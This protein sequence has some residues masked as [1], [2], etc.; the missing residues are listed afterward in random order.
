MATE[1][2]V[3]LDLGNDTLKISYAYDGA[4]GES[5]GKLMVGD[6]VNHVAIPAMA[7]YDEDERIW[8]FADELEHTA[9]K[10][11][12][13]V[14]KIKSILTM[15][16][17]PDGEE[18]ASEN[19]EY[20]TGE[21]L[22]PKFCFPERSK[23]EPLFSTLVEK[24]L[25]FKA[26]GTTPKSLCEDF[27]KYVK[28]IVTEQIN[29]L[30]ADS[31]VSFAPLKNIA[32]VYPPKQG[33]NYVDE[34]TRLVWTA[35]GEEPQTVLTSTQ[36]LGLLAFHKR[37]IRDDERALIFDMGDETVS[38]AKVWLNDNE[39]VRAGVLIDSRSA[40]SEPAD[41]GGS[42]ID[43]K[44][45]GFIADGIYHR[46]SIGSPSSGEVGHIY[47]NGLFSNQY[48]M[49]KDIKKSKTAMPLAGT[50]MFR[51]GVPITV[52]REVLVQRLITEYDFEMCVGT[53]ENDGVAKA[54]MEYIFE[55]LER[56]VNRDI[57]KI[58][59]AGG[60]IETH[61]L[62]EYIQRELSREYGHIRVYKFEE[63]TA[64]YETV[65]PYT[66]QFY[67]ASAYSSSLGGAIV[68]MRNYSVDN[69]LSYSYGTW[70][71]HPGS[72]KKH[73]KL[74][75]ERGSLLKEKETRFSM[76]ASIMVDRK[77]QERIDGDELFS[78]IINTKEI[79]AHRYSDTL[80]YEDDFLI[81]GNSGDEDR[82]RAEDVIDLRI[83]GGGEGTEVNFYYRDE[84]VSIYT[85]T[86]E[87][88]VNFEEGF[89]VDQN[90]RA[91]PFFS[92]MRAYNNA[93]IVARNVRTGAIY[94]INSKDI[95]FKLQ[96]TDIEPIA[97]SK[98]E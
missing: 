67:E 90:G 54:L 41:I 7:Y 34:L 66:I 18:G 82:S 2:Y 42:D 61:V 97:T 55:E 93:S 77:P 84:R 68:A 40:H 50:G 37:M 32:I 71:Y 15:F 49:M 85:K 94:N 29:G 56:A 69:V 26:P 14:V 30:S 10:P 45:A 33:K 79:L 35:F 60:M 12:H 25:V 43:E 88:P 95:D 59:F 11:F 58:I 48:L 81:I 38:V 70:L 53:R 57:T 6:L 80:T 52:H 20:Y 64:E 9:G 16:I 73:L 78:T 31:G 76:A 74:F 65:S 92:N 63:K 1:I 87:V 23:Q 19:L 5:Y 51:D 4:G 75:A 21:E 91:V 83:V 86:G 36:A 17:K 98:Q 46:E 62:L 39:A 28:K 72:D 44:L 8:K 3:C 22:F 13:T 47:E 89:V 96:I 24:M 27:F